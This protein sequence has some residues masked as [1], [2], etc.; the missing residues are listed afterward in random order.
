MYL[1]PQNI[2]RA[3]V[4]TLGNKVVLY[5]LIVYSTTVCPKN[6]ARKVDIAVARCV[7]AAR[8]VH[9][10]VTHRAAIVPF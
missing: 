5:C 4:L 1:A 8:F 9:E 2:P 10:V 7:T 3:I 6:T